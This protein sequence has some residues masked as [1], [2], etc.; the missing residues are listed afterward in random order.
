MRG[1]GYV[2][3][4][5][6][7]N[8]LYLAGTLGRPLLLEGVPGIGKTSCATALA[9]ACGY[10]L[11]RLQCHAMIDSSQALYDWDYRRQLLVARLGQLEPTDPTAAR[12]D[13]LFGESFLLERPLL[14][15][16]RSDGRCVLLIDEVD[17]SDEEFEALLL[18]FLADFTISIPELGTVGPPP[19][20]PVVIL[21]S[22]ATRELHGALKRRC[23]YHWIDLPG[24]DLERQIVAAAVPGADASMVAAV[25]DAVARIREL[26]LRRPPGPAET[27]DWANALVAMSGG[28][29]TA[30]SARETIGVVVKV[31]DDM[32]R[33]A[34]VLP[35]IVGD[36]SSA[37]P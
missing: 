28:V 11:I 20:H 34:P 8:A 19:A 17:R 15:A 14:R 22:N 31:H 25:V 2:A 1:A 27:V 16:L 33:V 35:D 36:A 37:M 12:V 7:V 26:P 23:L 24:A 4:E 3:A 29:L 6:L 30:Q 18:E 13:S 32:S 10:P 5:G 9:R 21:T